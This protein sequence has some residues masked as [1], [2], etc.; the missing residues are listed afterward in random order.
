MKKQTKRARSIKPTGQTSS[1]P[2][3]IE[4][5]GRPFP[6]LHAYTLNEPSRC[7]DGTAALVDSGMPDLCNDDVCR[8]TFVGTSHSLDVV[9]WTQRFY[10]PLPTSIRTPDLSDG[11][12]H[13]ILVVFGG[14][15]YSPRARRRNRN[16]YEIREIND[17]KVLGNFPSP[18]PTLQSQPPQREITISP[19]F[20]IIR[21][22]GHEMKFG[23][24]LKK[25]R[26]LQAVFRHKKESGSGRFQA[27]TILEDINVANA[28][29]KIRTEKLRHDLFKNMTREF[30][31]LFKTIDRTNH[32]YEL[33]PPV[34]ADLNLTKQLT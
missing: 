31:L 21:W 18:A 4:I 24:G 14:V 7:Y 22:N 26:F 28:T 23:K 8:T 9:A 3:S 20:R 11:E 10:P 32:E 13:R 2:P 19:D 33:V 5:N 1:P 16:R 25:R 34:P 17:S 27:E 6:V 30:D 15:P 29:R 12:Y